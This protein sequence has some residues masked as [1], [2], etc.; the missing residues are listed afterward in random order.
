MTSTAAPRPPIARPAARDAILLTVLAL[1]VRFWRLG[2]AALLPD[3]SYYWLWSQRLAPA[4]YDNAAGVAWMIRLSTLLGGSS[5]WGVRWL[6]AALGAAAAGLAYLVGEQLFSRRAGVLSALAI[7]LGAPYLVI[8]RWV[9]TD[10]LQLFLLLL[11]L[12]LIVSV[13][14][15]QGTARQ[16][17]AGRAPI[18]S[19][20]FWAIGL[21]MAELFNTKYNA[22]LYAGAIGIAVLVWRRSLL[23]DRRTWLAV[24]LAAL[25]ALPV[26]WWNAAHNWAS[27]RWQWAHFV[28][29]STTALGP[30]NPASLPGN[31]RHIWAYVTPPL[32]ALALPGLAMWH[33]SET[34]PWIEPRLLLVPALALVV[35]IVLSPAGS[36]RNLV[37]GLALLLILGAGW[38]DRFMRSRFA[39]AGWGAALGLILLTAVY[40]AGTILGSL[41]PTAW[42]RSSVADIVRADSRGWRDAATLELDADIPIF[43]LDYG[44]AAQLS[45]YLDRPV[46]TSWGQY[47]LWG[48]PSLDEVQIVALTFVD[49][50]LVSARLAET[51]ARV[52]GP[53]TT[54]LQDRM[55]TKPLWIWQASGM[56]VDMEVFLDRLDFLALM[57]ATP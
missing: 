27:F 10:A 46:Y 54:Y 9:Y 47:R 35:P 48:I 30:L 4:Y 49:P 8:S 7:A 5:E 1:L 57:Q 33:A 11:N 43:A 39:A 18:H 16:D 6:N 40:G 21:S 32:V 56:R 44:I 42:P 34:R 50:D 26:L 20:W 24:G 31:L 19:G 2:E 37:N 25:G 29:G 38:I 12:Y 13:T 52:D 55:G 28:G 15:G 41:A 36:P 17:A 3:E 23:R 14:A 53:R 22:Y 51:F 45:Y